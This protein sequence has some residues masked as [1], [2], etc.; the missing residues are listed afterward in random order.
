MPLRLNHPAAPLALAAALAACGGGGGSSQPSMPPPVAIT[1]QNATVVADETLSTAL[2]PLEASALSPYV[3]KSA[4]GAAG[5]ASPL[6]TALRYALVLPA[7]ALGVQAKSSAIEDCPAGGSV[8]VTASD[9]DNSGTPSAGDTLYVNFMNCRDTEGTLNG[10]MRIVLR[11]YSEPSPTQLTLAADLAFENLSAIR[12][13]DTLAINGT[14][15]FSFVQSATDNWTQSF[16]SPRLSLA[17][18]IDGRSAARQL[19]DYSATATRSSTGLSTTSTYAARGT[20]GS[21]AMG[22][23]V[24]FETVTPFAVLGNASVPTAGQMRVTGASGSQLQLA[25]QPDGRL[26]SQLDADG[27]GTVDSSTFSEW[28]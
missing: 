20:L 19:A 15:D 23:S 18:V 8:E 17:G 26:L 1:T 7:A 12:G 3:L 16:S 24:S 5:S 14:L 2:A 9:A 11:S 4:G 27:N 21:D 6:P 25:A 22:G 10:G 13:S 28:P